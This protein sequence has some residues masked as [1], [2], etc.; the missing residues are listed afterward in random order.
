MAPTNIVEIA[1][2]VVLV[3]IA[4][5]ALQKVLRIVGSLPGLALAAV[6]AVVV[7]REMNAAQ[8]GHANVLTPLRQAVHPFLVWVRAHL[9]G[10]R[11]R[12]TS[13][14]GNTAGR[15][16]KQAITGSNS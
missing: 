6:A 8:G 7:Y 9:P 10:W 2:I 16:A 14:A 11:A 1:G 15:Y 12:I 13:V 4:F 3:V 5:Y